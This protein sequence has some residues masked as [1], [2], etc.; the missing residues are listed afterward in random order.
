MRN[1]CSR[2]MKTSV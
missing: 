2:L 1:F